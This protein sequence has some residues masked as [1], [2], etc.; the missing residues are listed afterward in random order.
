TTSLAWDA[1]YLGCA[2]A[3][4]FADATGTHER[5][6]ARLR[7]IDGALDC[8]PGLPVAWSVEEMLAVVQRLLR[9]PLAASQSRETILAQWDYRDVDTRAILRRIVYAPDATAAA[10][11]ALSAVDAR[12]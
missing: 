2:V 9:D 12:N 3:A 5:R 6:G 11:A 10:V 7:F 4:N 8:A 1:A